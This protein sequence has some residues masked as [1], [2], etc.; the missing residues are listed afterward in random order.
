[1]KAETMLDCVQVLKTYSY[2]VYFRRDINYFMTKVHHRVN[3]QKDKQGNNYQMPIYRSTLTGFL[4]LQGDR[5]VSDTL[6][7]ISIY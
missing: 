2:F 7:N 5:D 4:F 1:M 3:Q 6:H